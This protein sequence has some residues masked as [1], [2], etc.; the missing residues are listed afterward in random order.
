MK[1]T[2]DLK[3]GKKRSEFHFPDAGPFQKTADAICAEIKELHKAFDLLQKVNDELRADQEVTLE[4]RTQVEDY[5]R[6]RRRQVRRKGKSDFKKTRRFNKNT[7]IRYN[8]LSE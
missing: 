7:N 1:S 6:K 3:T 5:F 8:K 4:T 2:K